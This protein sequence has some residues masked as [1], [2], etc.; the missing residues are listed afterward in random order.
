M[1]RDAKIASNWKGRILV[2]YSVDPQKKGEYCKFPELKIQRLKELKQHEQ[3]QLNQQKEL[4]EF[5]IIGEFGRLIC[6]PDSQK[7]NLSFCVAEY[8]WNT[9]KMDRKGDST[10]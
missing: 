5:L 7:Y 10:T 9:K 4:N 2:E 1:N 3:N 6:L 8:E